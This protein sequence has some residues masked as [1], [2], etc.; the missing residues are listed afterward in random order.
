M[1]NRILNIICITFIFIGFQVTSQTKEVK[2][3]RIEGNDV[4]FS[5]DKREYQKYIK[6]NGKKILLEDFN[7][8]NVV[9]S[10]QFNNWSKNKWRM[11]KVDENIYELRKSID[12]FDDNFTWE[13]KFVINNTHWAEPFKNDLN[14][15]KAKKYGFNLGVYNLN[16][17]VN[18]P[19][20][21]GN[22]KFKLRGHSSAKKV[23]LSGSFNKWNER[24]FLMTKT[25]EGWE[26]NLQ[27]KPGEYEYKFIIDG[28]WIE[29]IDNPY[30]RKNEF[31]GYNSI[32]DIREYVT[33]KLKGYPNAKEII[34]S[35]SFNNWSE[36]EYKMTNADG[37]WKY[38]LLLSGGKHH[39][40]YII[41]NKWVVDPYN[42]VREY[43]SSGN[44][45]SVYMVK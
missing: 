11:T 36:N 43:D 10:G 22:A 18:H 44:I 5:F 42:P 7:I 27:L 26:L 29:D 15:V 21:N 1:R 35:G 17:F 9:V 14:I 30:K 4:V 34:L 33:F 31:D 25:E 28:H 40:K 45:N 20:K 19:V 38:T 37:L 24:M 39:Y 23:V 13:F 32:I 2:G 12:D 6:E 16:L 41:D 8:E 3:Y